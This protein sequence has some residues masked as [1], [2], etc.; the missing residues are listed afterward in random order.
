M[1]G[2][3]LFGF[4]L[5]VV[6]LSCFIAIFNC[7][8]I[9]SSPF[10]YSLSSLSFTLSATEDVFRIENEIFGKKTLVFLRISTDTH[11][12]T[13]TSDYNRCACDDTQIILIVLV[14]QKSLTE[15]RLRLI[16]KEVTQISVW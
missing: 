1:G 16:V 9:V 6:G 3:T 15:D 11:N 12:E 7:L 2:T 13:Q 4:L 14:A 5:I 8:S 10:I